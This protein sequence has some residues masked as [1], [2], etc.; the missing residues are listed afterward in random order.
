MKLI[1]AMHCIRAELTKQR[2]AKANQIR[3]LVAEYG[4]VA[5]K[6]LMHLRR[7]LPC[8]LEDAENGLS[9]RFRRLLNGLWGDLRTLDERIAEV[10]R[11]RSWLAQVSPAR[12]RHS[13]SLGFV[14][15]GMSAPWIFVWQ[16]RPSATGRLPPVSHD[17]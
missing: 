2:T 8:W 13:L 10:D 11:Q 6:E 9:A 14:P 1:Q 7:A 17:S 4:L 5:P 15:S 12:P 3:G 16:R